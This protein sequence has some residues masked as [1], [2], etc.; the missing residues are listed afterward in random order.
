VLLVGIVMLLM[1]TLVALGV[2]RMSMRHTQIVNNE[3]VRGEAVAAASYALD[4]V[5]NAPADTWDVY[6]G[7]GRTHAINIGIS[8]RGDDAAESVAVQVSGLHCVR[9]RLVKNGELVKTS[10]TVKYVASADA[11]C[12]GGGGTPLTIVD[13]S[14]IGSPND[15]SL[16]AAVLYQVEGRAA[17]DQLLGA[18]ATVVQGVSVRR[19]IDEL[20]TCD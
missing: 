19:G 7:A 13:P 16:C 6:R 11:P 9:S 8:S 4:L 10:G 15:D 1:V 14:A 3:Q 18:D 5:L 2:I 20:T 17:D 12:F